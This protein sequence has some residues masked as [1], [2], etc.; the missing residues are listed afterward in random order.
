V[1]FDRR[2]VLHVS[3]FQDESIEHLVERFSRVVRGARFFQEQK[4]RRYFVST[5]ERRRAKRAQAIRRERRR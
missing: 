1:G 2:D 5:Q 3:R 4:A